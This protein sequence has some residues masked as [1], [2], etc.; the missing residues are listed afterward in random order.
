[1]V[2]MT[3]T[4]RERD[5]F[6]FSFGIE[7]LGLIA[8]KRPVLSAVLMVAVSIAALFGTLRLSVDDSL[9]ELFRTDTE[10]FRRY[11]EVASRF[12]SSEYDVL[13]VVEGETLLARESIDALRNTIL[14]FNLVGSVQG[15]VSLFSARGQP[16]ATGYAPP[17]FPV[18]LPEGEAYDEIVQRVRENE[19]VKGKL[20][21]DDGQLALIVL[22]LNR[23]VVEQMGL[24]EA[25]QQIRDVVNEQLEGTGLTTRFTG[26]PVMQLEIRNAVNRD[27]LLYNGLGFLLGALI[28]YIFFRRV[29]LMLIAAAGPAAAVLW[30]LGTIG[31]MDFRLNLFVNVIIPLITVNGFSDSMHLVFNIRRDVMAGVDRLTAAR[32]AIINVAPACFLTALTAAIALASFIFAQSALIR[33]FGVASTIAVLLAYVAVV[34]VVPVLAALLLRDEKKPEG[35]PQESDGA[36]A[37][38]GRISERLFAHVGRNPV[39]YVTM[40]VVLVGLSGAAYVS[41]DPHYRLA[42]Q[43]PDREQALAATGRLDEKLTG[44]NPVHIMVEWKDGSSLYS[45]PVLDVIGAA[46]AIVENQS[47]VG[48]VW[49]VETLRRWLVEAGDP[50]LATLEKY[51]GILPKHLTRRFVAETQDAILITGRLPDVDASE[52]LPVVNQLNE[53]LEAV[54]KANPG[55]EISVTGLP[56]IAARN[57]AQMIFELNVGLVADIVVVIMILGL[58]F[59]SVFAGVVSIL[60][61]LFPI[62]ATGALLYV[63][64]TGMHFASIIALTVAF[65]LALDSTIHFL[66]RYHLEET[67]PDGTPRST[68]EALAHTARMIGP[69]LI[70]TTIVLALGLG[71]TILSDLPSL[72]TFG[73][74]SGI[75]LFAALV[76]QLIILPASI[77]LARRVWKRKVAGGAP[78]TAGAAG[79]D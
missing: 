57:S 23:P 28:A 60:P 3:G 41:L 15:L 77:P 48:N 74:L 67:A 35:A 65:G 47:G 76:A 52:I 22:A 7:R 36:M 72:R 11:E 6:W 59:R 10:E 8:L 44:A 68:E 14:E 5:T 71:V 42:D 46:H 53:K 4:T 78:A 16:D 73:Q 61:S 30:A 56:A 27:R 50:S 37:L 9:S 58:A 63:T 69:V 45:E 79:D 1:M 51:V 21:S 39:G 54:R 66:N 55:F 2:D 24:G 40:G 13:V 70:L 18:D 29:S 49:S 19:I 25:I 62:F 34:M 20:L 43:V 31:Y 75:T 17:L 38:L 32:N 64:G 12:P 26:A 33:T